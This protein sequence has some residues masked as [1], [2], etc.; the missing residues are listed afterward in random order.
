MF[1]YN[2]LLKPSRVAGSVKRKDTRSIRQLSSQPQPGGT[3]PVASHPDSVMTTRHA[4]S[5]RRR[6]LPSATHRGVPRLSPL[7]SLPTHMLLAGAPRRATPQHSA[8]IQ[9]L[10]LYAET[11]AFAPM[12]AGQI[13][14]FPVFG[15]SDE[16]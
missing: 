11:V 10:R 8:D 12:C 1:S 9:S 6:S 15:A 3:L 7:V 4:I 2:L 14:E 16:K 5:K 13:A